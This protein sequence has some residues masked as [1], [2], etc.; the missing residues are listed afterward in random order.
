VSSD[1]DPDPS[2]E[3][4]HSSRIFFIT[5]YLVTREPLCR[6]PLRHHPVSP[7]KS[8]PVSGESPKVDKPPSPRIEKFAPELPNPPSPKG[9]QSPSSAKG[10]LTSPTC[11]ALSRDVVSTYPRPEPSELPKASPLSPRSYGLGALSGPRPS[12]GS[13]VPKSRKQSRQY[14]CVAESLWYNPDFIQTRFHIGRYVSVAVNTEAE[15]ENIK[16]LYSSLESI[17]AQINVSIKTPL[18]HSFLA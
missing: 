4:V 2:I 3:K 1:R 5:D 13:S 11:V 10:A 17:S 12:E 14:S 15:L 6:T 9:A 8:A 7:A 16:S 18:Y